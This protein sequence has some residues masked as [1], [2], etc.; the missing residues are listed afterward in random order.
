MFLCT[1]Q[2]LVAACFFFYD[3]VIAMHYLADLNEEQ[4]EAALHT[5]GPLLIIAG[6]G[7][8]KTKTLTSR[9]FHLIKSGVRPSEILAITFTNKAAKEMRDRIVRLIREDKTL[10]LP[11]TFDELPFVSTFHALGVSVLRRES[12]FLDL[13]KH[14]TIADDDDSLSATKEAVLAAGLN[15][16]QFEPRRMK[17]AISREKGELMT[18]EKYAEG[19]DTE[20][21]PRMLAQVWEKYESILRARKSLDFD[22]LILK[23]VRLLEQHPEVRAQYRTLW[24][25]IH[26]D[27]YQD[28]NTAQYRLSLL[29]AGDEKNICVVGDIDQS[30]YAWRG[31]DF[32]NIMNFE[33]D[34]P[35]AKTV[36]LEE[37]YRS[38]KNI[39]DAANA[40]IQKNTDRKEKNLFTRKDG[41]EKIGLYAAYDEEDEARFIAERTRDLISSGAEPKDIAVL[42]RANFQSR[43]LEDAMLRTDI[44]YQV[45]GV[46]FFARKEVK[47]VLSFVRVALNPE[48][49]ADYARIINVPPRGVGKATLA[50]V[51]AGQEESLPPAMREK[52][53]AFRAILSH[54]KEYALSRKPSE[55]ISFII[56][57]SGMETAYKAGT[58][59]DRERLENAYELSHL[60]EKYDALSPEEGTMKLL[61]DAALASDQDSLSHERPEHKNAVRL[62]TVHASKGL[63]F[64]Y[65]FVTGLE[66]DLFP[67]GGFGDRD[68]S[69]R[70]EEERRLFYVAVTRAERKLF[71][72]F[73]SVRTIFGS[74]RVNIPSEFIS[75]IPE[76]LV[77]PD[78]SERVVSLD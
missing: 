2:P 61:E 57:Q 42:Y 52:V 21:F 10:N 29:L 65:V 47:D 25:F 39:L 26:I 48:S 55:T 22:D 73:A 38:T 44:P 53:S 76:E 40:I 23:T 75:D 66:E 1:R 36:L 20:Y 9:M 72:S 64:P 56:K 78:H 46:K 18:V 67:H 15:P 71:L 6:A 41:G 8:G 54:I 3:I 49:S 5:K 37:N 14:F 63:E 69:D 28:T 17:N 12:R 50:K 35:E 31:A 19:V 74:R 11:L 68:S 34:F 51:L 4:K 32:R 7:A 60:A 24:R 58:D 45:L 13:P 30:I 59:E 16:K 77:E 27:E 62:M 70:A 43:V 33:R